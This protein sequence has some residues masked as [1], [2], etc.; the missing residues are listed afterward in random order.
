MTERESSLAPDSP[1]VIQRAS[2]D[3][4]SGMGVYAAA[5]ALSSVVPV[6][7]L[8]QMLSRL[9]RGA[10]MRRVARRHGVRL[11]GEAREVL[12][13]TGS[14]DRRRAI[15]MGLLRRAATRLL[16]PLRIAARLDDAVETFAAAL[17]L[18]HYLGRGGR[19]QGAPLGTEEARRV[20]RAMDEAMGSGPL[21][22][23]RDAP[24][25]LWRAV[26]GAGRAAATPDLE[27]RS[28]A[29]RLV[30]ALLDA[31]ADAPG[32]LGDDLRGA[33]DRALGRL[34]VER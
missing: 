31:A 28:P 10:A 13:R 30:D 34:E 25:G 3:S 14:P 26:V 18:D 23:L 4:P 7:L 8:D 22:S 1:D 20:R 27:D 12:A 19:E 29:E 16:P 21:E 5:A 6:P 11:T 15:S 32:E 33:F 9:A 24:G 2:G 17:L